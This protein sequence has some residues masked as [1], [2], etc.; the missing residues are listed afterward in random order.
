MQPRKMG[1]PPLSAEQQA[2]LRT[3]FDNKVPAIVA[4]S[5]VGCGRNTAMTYYALFRAGGTGREQPFLRPKLL[6]VV[7]SGESYRRL[8]RRAAAA[9][10][11]P[12]P[13]AARIL[14]DAL[15]EPD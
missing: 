7:I 6:K 11:K 13:M 3:A 14:E 2:D 9:V 12:R 4:A 8:Q 15:A 1:R 5:Q 10:E